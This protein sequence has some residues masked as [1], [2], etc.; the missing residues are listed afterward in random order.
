MRVCLSGDRYQKAQDDMPI[1]AVLTLVI[2]VQGLHTVVTFPPL[3]NNPRRDSGEY[4]LCKYPAPCQ[5]LPISV[6]V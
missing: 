1:L 6:F 2:C 5:T 4:L 3:T